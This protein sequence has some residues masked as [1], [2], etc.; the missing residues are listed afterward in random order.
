MIKTAVYLLFNSHGSKT[1][2]IIKGDITQHHVD[3]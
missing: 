1:A 2:R 3:I